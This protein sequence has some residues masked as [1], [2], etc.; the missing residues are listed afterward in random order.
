MPDSADPRR[1]M[2]RQADVSVD[3]QF[4][5]PGKDAHTHL[6]EC[7]SGPRV[8]CERFLARGGREDGVLRTCK[9]DKERVALV[10]DLPA[11]V[12]AERFP[13]EAMVIGEDVGVLAAMRTEKLRRTFNVRE[14]K[15]RRG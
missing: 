6:D 2:N 15:G 11:A 10:V 9:G 7:S 5:L 3:R 14:Q 8:G 12:D 13:N 4:C 1:A